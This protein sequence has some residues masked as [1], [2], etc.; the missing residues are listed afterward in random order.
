MRAKPVYREVRP[1][2]AGEGEEG[3]T[4]YQSLTIVF[5]EFRELASIYDT[6][7]DLVGGDLLAEICTYNST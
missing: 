2:Q 3:I 4:C 5:L 6:S 1:S 7:D